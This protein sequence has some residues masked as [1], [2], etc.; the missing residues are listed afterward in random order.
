MADQR[1]R[2]NAAAALAAYGVQASQPDLDAVRVAFE[3]WA[4]GEGFP[5]DLEPV[6]GPPI[7]RDAAT[8][9]AWAAWWHLRT[10]G[11]EGLGDAQA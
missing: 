2:G 4:A 8:R 5:L 10:S 9:G 7:Y 11:V 1:R 3:R 6:S